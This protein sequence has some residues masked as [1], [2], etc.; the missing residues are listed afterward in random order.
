MNA[1]TY[2]DKNLGKK[3]DEDKMMELHT[4]KL[5]EIQQRELKA[6]KQENM[7]MSTKIKENKKK[8]EGFMK[9]EKNAEINRENQILLNKLV[10]ISNGKWS[11]VTKPPVKKVKKAPVLPS[12][13]S[14][15]YERRKKEFERIE[16]ENMAIAQRLFNKQGSISK[17][18]MDEDYGVSRKYKKQIQKAEGGAAIKGKARKGKTADSILEQSA[19]QEE[20]KMDDNSDADMKDADM[21]DATKWEE[22]DMNDEL[23]SK[24]EPVVKEKEI[25]LNNEV[26]KEDPKV[27]EPKKEEIK[28]EEPKKEEPKEE[29]ALKEESANEVTKKEEVVTKVEEPKIA[30][31][32]QNDKENNGEVVVQKEAVE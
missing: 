21:K 19:K 32:D 17:K 23:V 13:K 4:K 9:N 8:V 14:L 20:D 22:D 29:E 30:S 2:I 24:E 31:G 1:P 5:K 6:K 7:E 27:E 25:D 26:K 12:K 16:R 10:E 28:L 18:K 3:R 15:N 11:S